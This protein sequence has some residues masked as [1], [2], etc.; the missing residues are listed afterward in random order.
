MDDF[1]EV[2]IHTYIYIYRKGGLETP[3]TPQDLSKLLKPINIYL[4]KRR[5]SGRTQGGG[6]L[7][8]SAPTQSL[9]ELSESMRIS[10]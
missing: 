10:L 5:R 3:Q 6:S 2:P 9:A 1:M 7:T 4:P 8:A